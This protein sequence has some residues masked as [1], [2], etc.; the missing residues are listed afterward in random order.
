MAGMWCACAVCI[1][2]SSL[3]FEYIYY[4]YNTH[5]SM[6]SIATF[7]CSTRPPIRPL[8][9]A[10][11]SYSYSQSFTLH[12]FLLLSLS[13]S[14]VL[15][16]SPLLFSCF[17][18]LSWPDTSAHT[19]QR[20]IDVD[21]FY[22]LKYMFYGVI[23]SQA[24]YP[25]RRRKHLA[26]KWVRCHFHILSHRNCAYTNKDHLLCHYLL[27]AIHLS[28]P[29]FL[30]SPS[31]LTISPLRLITHLLHSSS[32]LRFTW[33]KLYIHFH[34]VLQFVNHF[35]YEIPMSVTSSNI[36]LICTFYSE[37]CWAK[38]LILCHILMYIR[39][40][41]NLSCLIIMWQ[42]LGLCWCCDWTIKLW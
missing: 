29:H 41:I 22:F 32:H 37:I 3:T 15:R 16:C 11:I 24:D 4:M 19:F 5:Q 8:R 36:K 12:L 40:K 42:H 25:K 38:S 34:Y 27:Y 35:M 1:I 23:Y 18:P 39:Q 2:Q 9:H 21:V 30:C 13:Q 20:R 14:V 7:L 28:S 26:N 6:Y 33:E 31:V 17:D 10:D